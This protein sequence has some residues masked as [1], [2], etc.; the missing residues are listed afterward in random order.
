MVNTWFTLLLVYT[1]FGPLLYL[2]VSSPEIKILELYLW[3]QRSFFW[4]P[5]AHACC[6]QVDF[7]FSS[8]VFWTREYFLHDDLKQPGGHD[9]GQEKQQGMEPWTFFS[10]K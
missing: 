6:P 9:S 5:R 3:L 7:S 8:P 2:A 1:E 10:K 4:Y